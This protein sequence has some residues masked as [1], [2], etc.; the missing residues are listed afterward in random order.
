MNPWRTGVPPFG[1]VL[2]ADDGNGRVVDV[3]AVAGGEGNRHR[4]ADAGY[5]GAC[6][7]VWTH[8]AYVRWRYKEQQHAGT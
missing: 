4:W 6:G 2:E 1:V 5:C 3:I 8:N 7:A